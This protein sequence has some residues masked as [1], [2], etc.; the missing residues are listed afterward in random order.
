MKRRA[1][2][3]FCSLYVLCGQIRA[4]S[5]HSR[6]PLAFLS[7]SIRVHPWLK[8]FPLR[9]RVCGELLQP[10]FHQSINPPIH[11]PV[12]PLVFVL[13]AFFAAKFAPIRVIRVNLVFYPCPSVSIRG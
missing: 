13:F 1:S 7:V 4:N 12:Q 6:Q 2:L 9:L 5:R 8:Y 11:F 10:K 3:S